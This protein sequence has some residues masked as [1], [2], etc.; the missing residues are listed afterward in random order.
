[1]TRAESLRATLRTLDAQRADAYADHMRPDG[2]RE[3]TMMTESKAHRIYGAD[4]ARALLD[5][6]TPGPWTTCLSAHLYVVTDD[7]G[8]EPDAT[9]A[10]V[11][12][13]EVE[14]IPTAQQTGDALLLAAAP[15]LAASVEYH[16][17]RADAAEQEC[18]RL[19]AALR[20]YATRCEG[21]NCAR[22]AT[23]EDAAAIAAMC[24][25]CASTDRV[26]EWHQRP[27]ADVLRSLDG[28]TR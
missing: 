10:T 9:G 22:L 7:G 17:A 28:V 20:E 25:E 14:H 6:T 23:Q 3:T 18:A 11:A 19:R 27:H 8:E 1:M 12:A 13:I 16:A 24:D 4:E 15:D 26:T 21:A 5:G 2:A